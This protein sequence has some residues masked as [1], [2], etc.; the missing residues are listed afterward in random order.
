[1]LQ[2]YLSIFKIA[3][4]LQRL[5]NT[6]NVYRNDRTRRPEE[7]FA[8]DYLALLQTIHREC[9][10]HNIAFTSELAE[11]NLRKP[12]PETYAD[13]FSN[14]CHLDDLLS[15]EL[16]KE[17]VFHVPADR[18]NYFEQDNLFG[19]EVGVAFPSCARDIRKA[20]DCYALSQEDA[21]VHHL[22]LVLDRGLRILASKVGVSFSQPNW[23]LLIDRIES[24]IKSLPRSPELTF[25]REVN[26][27]FGFLKIA[28]RNHSEHAHDDPYDL[29]KALSILNHVRAFMQELQKGGLA[30]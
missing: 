21:C 7:S 8:S 27:Q 22:M 9:L 24:E 11:R 1:M 23:Q 20:G 4:E 26:A 2:N 5:R 19:L 10:A 12:A 28:Y 18:K 6:A 3:L 30:E 15:S 25:Y 16:E 17:A 29:E 13:A 14:L